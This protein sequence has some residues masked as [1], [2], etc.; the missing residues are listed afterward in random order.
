MHR[1]MR[2][3]SCWRVGRDRWV[4]RR[5]GEHEHG[6]RGDG[7]RRESL[8]RS[9]EPAD[10]RACVTGES[11]QRCSDRVPC[12]PKPPLNRR[13][14]E[15]ERIGELLRRPTLAARE[16]K[17]STALVETREDLARR[18]AFFERGPNRRVDGWVVEPG[19][20]CLP[21]VG[22]R[23]VATHA[24][25]P[26]AVGRSAFRVEVVSPSYDH[27]E[28]VLLRVVELV[29]A[30]TEVAQ[31]GANVGS[32]LGDQ[33]SYSGH[34]CSCHERTDFGVPDRILKRAPYGAASAV[35]GGRRWF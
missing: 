5:L 4:G 23:N 9:H 13:Q 20:S 16:P 18:D 17:D 3:V 29:T 32:V 34:G 14:G 19:A 25:H 30:D 21:A 22:R 10:P 35:L 1:G 26:P 33:F 7:E 15:G 2:L 11:T 6:E 8:L 27:Q 28:H 31:R 24:P 12:L